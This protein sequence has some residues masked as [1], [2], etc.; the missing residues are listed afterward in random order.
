MLMTRKHFEDLNGFDPML[1]TGLQDVDL[2]LR[3]MNG[4]ADLIFDPRAV[5]IHMESLSLKPKLTD[6]HI[7]R[8]RV[9]EHHYFIRRWG[10]EI[11]KDRWMNPLLDPSDETLL[12]LR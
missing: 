7:Q 3:A 2:S 6:Q 1:A 5:L 8:C 9:N 11:R 4:G 12:T 10:D